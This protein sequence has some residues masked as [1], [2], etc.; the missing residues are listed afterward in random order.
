[1]PCV[2]Q[3]SERRRTMT[4]ATT[5]VFA[6]LAAYSVA[7]GDRYTCYAKCKFNFCDHSTNFRVGMPDKPFTGPICMGRKRV[8]IINTGEAHLVMHK[9]RSYKFTP[10]SHYHPRGLMQRFS[11]SFFKIY[12]IPRY[13]KFSGVGH[14]VPQKNQAHFLDRKC[15]ILP[16]KAYQMLGDKHNVVDNLH[17][18]EYKRSCVAFMTKL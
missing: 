14:E 6:L 7:V 9:H 3:Q 2:Y 5:F 16:I 12:A 15:W 11:P 10:I 13:Y 8:G 18:R 17:P 4:R 1:M